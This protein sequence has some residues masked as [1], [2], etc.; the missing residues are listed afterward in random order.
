MHLLLEHQLADDHLQRRAAL[1]EGRPA[2]ARAAHERG[3]ALPA[4]APPRPHHR[5]LP[6]RPWGVVVGGAA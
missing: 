3:G 1:R 5:A 2:S 4:G 6:V